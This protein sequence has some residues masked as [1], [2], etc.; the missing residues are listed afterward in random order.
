MAMAKECSHFNLNFGTTKTGADERASVVLRGYVDI[1]D[2]RQAGANPGS[3]FKTSK[4]KS[5]LSHTASQ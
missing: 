4:L 2:L 5:L 3:D 1:T